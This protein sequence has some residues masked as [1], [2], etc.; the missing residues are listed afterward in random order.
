L[1][2][3]TIDKSKSAKIQKNASYIIG[4]FVFVG[5]KIVADGNVTFCRSPFLSE[6]FFVKLSSRE[7]RKLP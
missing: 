2:L 3:T 5:D 7:H 4:R 6:V 1:S